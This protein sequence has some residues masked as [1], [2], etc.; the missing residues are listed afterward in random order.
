[1]AIETQ[2]PEDVIDDV[3]R[4]ATRNDLPVDRTYELLVGVGLETLRGHSVDVYVEDGRLLFECP[5]CARIFDAP[6]A[7]IEHG[8]AEH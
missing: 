7:A 2:V 5:E 8:D 6:A 4:F 3:E 1:M